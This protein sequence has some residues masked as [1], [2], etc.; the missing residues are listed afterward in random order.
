MRRLVVALAGLVAAAIVGIA[1]GLALEARDSQS[2]KA[3]APPRASVSV[4]RTTVTPAV[5]LFGA[6][7]VAELVVVANTTL[8]DPD[9]VRVRPDFTPYAPFGQRQIVRAD[10]ATSARFTYRF[11][12]RCL[13][14]DCAP[15]AGRTVVEFPGTAVFYRFRG[16]Q[17]PGT[18]IVDWPPFEVAARVPTAGLAP[19]RWRADVTSLPAV[20]FERSPS[21]TSIALVSASVLLALLGVA[22]VWWLARPEARAE[23]EVDRLPEPRATA[24]ERALQLAREASLDGDSPERRK[25][26]ERVARELGSRGR[27]DLA[28]RARA[29]AWASGASSPVLI[30]ELEREALATT[31]GRSA[32]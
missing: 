7:V 21:A 24:L 28:D 14:E 8:V 1:I 27:G 23:L 19:E 2:P 5:A 15:E 10:T 32:Q 6:P 13:D 25:A 20:T 17:G 3:A 12:L 18:A 9:T 16:A 22:L 30:D 11:T 29:L 31:N 4:V 26:F